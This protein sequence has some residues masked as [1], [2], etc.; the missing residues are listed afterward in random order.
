MDGL[1]AVPMHVEQVQASVL[2]DAANQSAQCTAEM[3]FRVG[4]EA[5]CPYFDLRQEIG[6]AALDG[7]S[8]PASELAHHDL[9]GGSNAELRVLERWLAAGSSHV[10]ALSYE[11]ATPE[12][13][14]AR[15]INWEPRSARLSFDLCLSDLNPARYLES[16][17]PSN[18]LFDRFPVQLEVQV[19]NASHLHALLSN[20]T[21][22]ELG[23][24]HWRVAFPSHF[25]P[26]SPLLLIEAADRVELLS[27][28][29]ALGGGVDVTLELMKRSS[30]DALD[31]QAAASTVAGYLREFHHRVGAYLHGDRFVAFLSSCEPFH[32]MEYAAGCT[33]TVATLEHEVFHS[34]WARG[35]IPARSEDGWL[36]EAWT[37]YY[38]SSGHPKEVVLDMSGPPV[39]LWT[40][41][42]FKRT[43]HSSA[44]I[45]GARVFAG[46]ASELGVTN[47]L[48][49]M[50]GIY[51]DREDR[52]YVT[53]EIEAELIRRSGELRIA[54][55]FDR[56][57]YGFGDPPWATEPDLYLRAADD[58]SGDRPYAG[59]PSVSPDVWVR[60]ED[61]EGGT[62]QEPASGRDNWFCA[63][64]HNRGSAAAGSFVVGF[65]FST[66]AGTGLVY[67]GD[68]LPLD[69]A[70]V[71]FNLPPGESQVLK[72]R[73][74]AQQIPPPGS[75]GCLLAL[76][77]SPHDLPSP[78][79]RVR[80]HNNLALRN[81]TVADQDAG[82][83]D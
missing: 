30:D 47:L 64:I 18:L 26:C 66:G 76:V 45:Y 4:P 33:A 56:F 20:G 46:L 57:V 2:F 52:R 48:G 1:T 16:W 28:V 49:H 13:P 61:D 3:Q 60:N 12:A 82:R 15:A 63:R 80:E 25:A 42:P 11:L 78:G 58:D 8:I 59:D 23:D 75:R 79:A 53:P 21:V 44:Y 31:L 34:W 69:G 74:P 41:N 24:N 6:M 10:L 39:A 17:L 51:K 72:A 67:P 27:C 50:A 43:T 71:G 83:P 22:T 65:R 5:G 77:Y 29:A 73:W 19:V 36:D 55:W 81:L 32:S 70:A 9:G 35:M 7:L 40:N 37:T 62:P 54:S 68:W 14:N 38:T